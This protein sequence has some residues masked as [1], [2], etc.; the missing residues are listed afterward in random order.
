MQAILQDTSSNNIGSQPKA[1]YVLAFAELW[2]RFSYYGLRA[3]LIFYLTSELGFSD[4]SAYGIY[5]MYFALASASSVAGGYLAD[6]YLGNRQ[7]IYLGG[8]FIMAGHLFL[9]LF[10]DQEL[11]NFGLAFIIAGTGFFKPNIT[12]LVGQYYQP[13]DPRRDGG[14]TIFYMGINLGAFLA[15][16]AC[17]YIGRKYGWHYGFSISG[18][19]ILL[20]LLALYFNRRVLGTAGLNP[21]QVRLTPPRFFNLSSYQIIILG[22]LLSIPV[23]AWCIHNHALIGNFLPYFGLFTLGALIMVAVRCIGEERKAMFTLILMMPFFVAFWTSFEQAGASIN[24]FI[25]RHVDRNFMGYEIETAWFL[26]LTPFLIL[27]LGP[28]F[29]LLWGQLGRRH[30][31]L[32]TPLKFAAAFFQISFGFWLLKLGVTEGGDTFTTS[33]IWVILFYGLRTTGELCISPIALSMV[34]KLAP[35]R[36]TSFM[37]GV[38]FLSLAFANFTAQQVAQYFTTA[39]QGLKA[40]TALQDKATSFSTFGQ[41]FEFLMYLPLIS[42]IIMVMVSPFLKKV[43]EKHR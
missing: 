27:I 30:R 35:Q 11:L 39:S 23:F 19:G 37:M 1:L 25:E 14:F 5:G 3:L 28:V 6:R 34:T 36:F 26:S 4:V 24:L 9:L 42:G 40:V 33:M 22:T 18:I 32:T 10:N 41:I 38:F 43:F 16:F 2:E 17:G 12:S 7:A 29:S 15:P 21:G 20:G 8:I 13:N 31:E